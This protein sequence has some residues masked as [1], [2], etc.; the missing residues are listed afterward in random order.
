MMEQEVRAGMCSS[1]EINALNSQDCQPL[2]QIRT[3]AILGRRARCLK[4][5]R[6]AST[7][8]EEMESVEK[9]LR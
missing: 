8:G 2:Q 9:C 1:K 5:G 4:I 3:W 6:K 7:A